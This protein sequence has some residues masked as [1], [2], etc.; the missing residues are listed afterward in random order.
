[1]LKPVLFPIAV[2]LLTSSSSF[3][4]TPKRIDIG[5][6]VGYFSNFTIPPFEYAK[7]YSFDVRYKLWGNG[8]HRLSCLWDSETS[9]Y[10]KDGAYFSFSPIINYV[11]AGVMGQE[12][13]LNINVPYKYVCN[14]NKMEFIDTDVLSGSKYSKSITLNKKVDLVNK[15]L[16]LEGKISGDT[17]IDVDALG[18]FINRQASV[19]IIDYKEAI[20]TDSRGVIPLDKI[21]LDFYNNNGHKAIE[22]ADDNLTLSISGEN[23]MDFDPLLGHGGTLSQKEDSIQ[24]PLRW[25]KDDDG[26]S[27]PILD[28]TVFGYDMGK[29][30]EA[31]SKNLSMP[32]S[33]SKYP[34][35]HCK[36]EN[37]STQL[38]TYYYEFDVE[39]GK[40]FFGS[41][42][43]SSW[44]VEVS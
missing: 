25:E 10:E 41:C 4:L 8:T 18:N 27:Y 2:V 40:D 17:Y 12:F 30:S 13:V 26:Y 43:N 33:Q 6:S 32:K 38:G 14:V 19:E 16:G 11:A 35:Y 28:E 39:K 5:G 31:Y 23:F 20:E 7:A 29:G 24:I 9:T 44:C 1:M 34:I 22:E 21:K 3:G 37:N 36:I 42:R 15:N